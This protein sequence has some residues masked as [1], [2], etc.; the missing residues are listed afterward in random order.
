MQFNDQTTCIEKFTWRWR[1][2][3]W[4]ILCLHLTIHCGKYHTVQNSLSQTTSSPIQEISWT[5]DHSWVTGYDSFLI[6]DL[7]Q[8][9][10]SHTHSRNP[11][12]N[13]TLSSQHMHHEQ[14]WMLRGAG[15]SQ[16]DLMHRRPKTVGG[17]EEFQS[18][19]P[20]P[21]ML[22]DKETQ[23]GILL[24]RSL[25]EDRNVGG[26]GD[27]PFVLSVIHHTGC[28]AQQPRRAPQQPLIWQLHAAESKAWN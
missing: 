2:R 12:V 24:P 6:K 11:G 7:V 8:L 14:L 20:F 17:E 9:S 18:G 3:F 5:T 25:K 10:L 22:S 4:V 15:P 21:S 26:E 19:T 16:E 27:N 13:T 23:R 28:Q 1:W